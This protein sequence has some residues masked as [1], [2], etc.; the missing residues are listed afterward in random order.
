MV[1]VFSSLQGVEVPT[2]FNFLSITR[3][4]LFKFS[5]FVTGIVDFFAESVAVVAL[6]SN[7]TLSGKDLS[8]TPTD[9]FSG[10]GDLSRDIVVRSILFVEQ[11]TGV[12]DLF[13]QAHHRHHIGVGTSLEVVVL[14]KLFILEVT[15]L[16]LNRVKLV[17]QCQVVLVTLLDLKNLSLQLRNE[18]VF[19]VACQMNTVVILKKI[20]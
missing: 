3:T 8:L 7:I 1:G 19:L 16:G 4:L 5:E 20:K 13:L 2:A 17:A 9:L 10:C 18:Q 14:E 11:E 12:V 15:V 6:L